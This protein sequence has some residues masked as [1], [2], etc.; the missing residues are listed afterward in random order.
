MLF[1]WLPQMPFTDNHQLDLDWVISKY[2]QLE[3]DEATIQESLEGAEAAKED[4]E[5]AAT[6][7]ANSATAAAG[8]ATAAAGNAEDAAETAIA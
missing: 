5:A 7:A 8:S 4:A 6:D 3:D 1:N 2:K